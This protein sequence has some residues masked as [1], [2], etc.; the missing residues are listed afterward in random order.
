MV[1]HLQ[2]ERVGEESVDFLHRSYGDA[3]NGLLP[4]P[5]QP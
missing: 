4:V 3:G 2:I 1:P 5:L